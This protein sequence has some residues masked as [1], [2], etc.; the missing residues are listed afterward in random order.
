[1]RGRQGLAA[2]SVGDQYVRDRGRSLMSMNAV[3]TVINKLAEL[4][5]IVI[6]IRMNALQE[7]LLDHSFIHFLY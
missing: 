5:K 2:L 6:L 4:D 1:V 7:W 3:Q